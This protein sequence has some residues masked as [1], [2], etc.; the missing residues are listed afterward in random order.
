MQWQK[1]LPLGSSAAIQGFF[2][3][4]ADLLL[5]ASTRETSGYHLALSR[6]PA[7]W[8]AEDLV[9]S[10]PCL[11]WRLWACILFPSGPIPLEHYCLSPGLLEPGIQSEL[12]HQGT[13]SRGAG[14]SP[15]LFWGLH[16][17]KHTPRLVWL[18]GFPAA[19]AHVH[20]HVLRHLLWG[21]SFQ[22]LLF[23]PLTM[24]CLAQSP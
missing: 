4:N 10:P 12:S 13:K 16:L 6:R 17:Y 14:L 19:N 7:P 3:G 24:F 23:L 1:L 9:H 11:P 15:P 21:L 20:C 22:D 18:P 2:V 5:D 8:R